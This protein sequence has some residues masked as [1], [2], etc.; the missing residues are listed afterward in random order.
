MS[1][2]KKTKSAKDQ[3]VDELKV[4]PHSIEAEQSVLGGL[5]LD[6]ISWDKVIE[7]VKEDDFY[8]PNHRLIFKTMETLGRR[9]QPF[10]VLTLAEALKNVGELES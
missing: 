7:L 4:P 6:N 2:T 10:D 9:N 1:T 8:R 5:M 3:K